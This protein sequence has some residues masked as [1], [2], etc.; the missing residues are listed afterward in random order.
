MNDLS[1]S[2][3]TAANYDIDSLDEDTLLL[4][5]PFLSESSQQFALLTTRIQMAQKSLSAHKYGGLSRQIVEITKMTKSYLK[6]VSTHLYLNLRHNMQQSS[7]LG[8]LLI[9]ERRAFNVNTRIAEIL[10]VCKG[11]HA[12]ADS[13]VKQSLQDLEDTLQAQR[14]YEYQVVVPFYRD[15]IAA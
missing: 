5:D 12:L 15:A 13:V 6:A 2:V 7:A 1:T 10:T 3:A 14:D 8:E 9:A 4:A 11:Q